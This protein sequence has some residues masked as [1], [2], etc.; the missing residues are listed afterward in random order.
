MIFTMI[1]AAA[2][3]VTAAVLWRT[4]LLQVFTFIAA[5][6]LRRMR[7]LPA[8]WRLEMRASEWN[9]EPLPKPLAM[10]RPNLKLLVS[11]RPEYN[12]LNPIAI[13]RAL[14][15]AAR[16]NAGWLRTDVR[17]VRVMPRGDRVDEN[18][19][20]W[21]G[22]FL[23]RVQS[24]GFQNLVIL[25]TPPDDVMQYDI[26]RRMD[27]WSRFVAACARELGPY[28]S[29]YQLM[30]EPNNP[31]FA[32]FDRR[33]VAEAIARGA[34]AIRSYQPHA[35]ISVNICMEIW[36]WRSYLENLLSGSGRSV[37]IVGLD[38]YPHTWTV[39]WQENW[40]EVNKIGAAIKGASPDSIWFNRRIAIM[41]TGFATNTWLRGEREQSRY[42]EG[43]AKVANDLREAAGEV[44]FIGLHEL[45][46]WDSSALLDPEAHFGIMTSDL[47]PKLAFSAVQ[48]L[49][50]ELK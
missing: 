10:T 2:A 46:D 38:H 36:A 4:R 17:W 1:R 25:S 44:E 23:R 7:R 29:G 18:A 6:G 21:Y 22:G 34:E 35:S 31:V 24:H 41:E 49:A 42:F 26:A 5:A 43:L 28:C 16:L 39:G 8:L 30:N 50:A 20:A 33:N 9:S 3:L 48:R 45:C 11:Y 40:R 47:V 13:E 19:L 37:D 27:I 12:S 14:A 32:F 15:G